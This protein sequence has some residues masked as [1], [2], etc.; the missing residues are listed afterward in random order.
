MNTRFVLFLVSIA[1]AL[2]ARPSET[3][4]W[5]RALLLAYLY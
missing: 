2:I 5:L 3:R 4:G 1:G